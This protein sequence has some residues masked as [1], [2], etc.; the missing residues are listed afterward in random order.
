[1]MI[2]VKNHS[3]Y[4]RAY[5][6]QNFPGGYTPLTP[7]FFWGA[8]P[9]RPPAMSFGKP[10]SKFLATPLKCVYAQLKYACCDVAQARPHNTD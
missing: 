8:A 4:F 10:L 2:E 3:K 5:N 7:H 9:P 6:F 1:M